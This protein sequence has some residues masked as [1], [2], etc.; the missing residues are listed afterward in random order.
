MVRSVEA[1]KTTVYAVNTNLVTQTTG[2]GADRKT[3]V[4]AYSG[5]AYAF[6]V[7]VLPIPRAEVRMSQGAS[8]KVVARDED[9]QPGDEFVLYK[10]T[11][12]GIFA[13]VDSSGVV[14]FSVAENATVGASAR[15]TVAANDRLFQAYNV[16]VTEPIV[17]SEG[18]S[19]TEMVPKG[20]IGILE[21]FIYLRCI[22]D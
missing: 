16:T 5:A 22:G 6:A 9:V 13:Q 8:M 21:L 18:K 1:G 3:E 7:E 11:E 14:T 10:E 4:L 15:F 17:T 2:S 20:S 12:S 19:Y